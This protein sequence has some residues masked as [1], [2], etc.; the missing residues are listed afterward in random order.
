MKSPPP[1]VC[2]A[3]THYG[4]TVPPRLATGLNERIAEFLAAETVTGQRDK[5]LKG[6]Q[7]VELRSNTTDVSFDGSLLHLHLV[8]G[9]PMILA[10]HLLDI[11]SAEMRLLAVRKLDV[12]LLDLTAQ[13]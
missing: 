8:K 13:V 9:S 5:G 2:I 10:A 3:A 11:N 6:V 12:T 1:A 7:S 4:V